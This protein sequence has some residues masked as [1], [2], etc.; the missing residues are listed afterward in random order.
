[1]LLN[2]IPIKAPDVLCGSILKPKPNLYNPETKHILI[3]KKYFDFLLIIASKE[4]LVGKTGYYDTA[5]MSL[6]E[7]VSRKCRWLIFFRAQ[8]N[9]SLSESCHFGCP[10]AIFNDW[11]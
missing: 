4:I 7:K 3:F 11:Q 6:K 10:K 1:M 2:V 8:K 9:E 5:F